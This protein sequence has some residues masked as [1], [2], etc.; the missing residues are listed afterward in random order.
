[1]LASAHLG[2]LLDGIEA[3]GGDPSAIDAVGLAENNLAGSQQIGSLGHVQPVG[4]IMVPEPERLTRGPGQTDG[5]SR[6][7]LAA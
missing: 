5:P 2:D 1:M 4:L 7:R 6:T 3:C